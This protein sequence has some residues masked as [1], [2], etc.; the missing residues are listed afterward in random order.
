MKNQKLQKI[1]YAVFLL[2]TFG[3]ILVISLLDQNKVR[4]DEAVARMDLTYVV[5]AVF[6][7]LVFWLLEGYTLR[8]VTLSMNKKISFGRSFSIG[9]IGLFIRGAHPVG[10]RRAAD[11]D[12][13]HAQERH[14]LG[15]RDVGDGG[16]VHRV[17]DLHLLFVCHC[18]SL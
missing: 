1:G 17:P 11:T 13:V 5:V 7:L 16:Q 15:H 2:F 9:L 10:H 3:V 4:L 12:P 18:Y 14:I 6:C 8:Y